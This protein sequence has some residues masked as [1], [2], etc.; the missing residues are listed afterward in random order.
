[1]VLGESFVCTTFTSRGRPGPGFRAPANREPGPLTGSRPRRCHTR[2][3]D[4]APAPPNARPP[5]GPGG[6]RPGK[7]PKR[8][9]SPLGRPHD[10]ALSAPMAQP[11]PRWPSP[12]G[13]ALAVT[14]TRPAACGEA[15]RSLTVRAAQ[16]LLLV[17]L[18]T[19]W[20]L[21]WPFQCTTGQPPAAARGSCCTQIPGDIL[22]A[23]RRFLVL[24]QDLKLLGTG[25]YHSISEMP[26]APITV[27]P[28]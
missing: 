3:G 13:P 11:A 12:S 22:N 16:P 5:P 27:L 14:M 6:P 20:L 17:A 9:L 8:D 15:K 28:A 18:L 10:P 2:V 19:C 1:M 4:Q 26:R 24:C 25:L 7:S 21:A 23:T